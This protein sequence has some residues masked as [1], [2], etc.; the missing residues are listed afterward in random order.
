[1]EAAAGK[2]KALAPSALVA[3]SRTRLCYVAWALHSGSSERANS[4][5]HMVDTSNNR[6][7]EK[8]NASMLP[9]VLHRILMAVCAS[10]IHL[11]IQPNRQD[12]MQVDL[13]FGLAQSAAAPDPDDPIIGQPKR[14]P[15][16]SASSASTSS[17]NHLHKARTHG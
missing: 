7:V 12:R 3:V 5:A 2:R 1:M 16:T 14:P 9:P 8:R 4:C 15:S 11:P 17:I 13:V 6:A 10:G